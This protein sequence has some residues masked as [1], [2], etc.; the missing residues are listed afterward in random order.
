MQHIRQ[1]PHGGFRGLGAPELAEH[2]EVSGVML[3]EKTSVMRD[4]S[5]GSP[6][7]DSVHTALKGAWLREGYC[8]ILGANLDQES[9]KLSCLTQSTPFPCCTPTVSGH[10]CSGY[11]GCPSLLAAKCCGF[12]CKTQA[13]AEVAHKPVIPSPQPWQDRDSV[14]TYTYMGYFSNCDYTKRGKAVRCSV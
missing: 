8:F 4:Q 7:S 2:H 13:S 6:T 12:T 5:G 11:L 10:V 14:F 3:A 9:A 1:W